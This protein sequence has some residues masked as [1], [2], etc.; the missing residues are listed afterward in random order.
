MYEWDC[1]YC[2]F[3]AGTPSQE[4]EHKKTC[5]FATNRWNILSR[6][7]RQTLSTGMIHVVGDDGKPMC[8][9]DAQLIPIRSLHDLI[10]MV[11]GGFILGRNVV[12]GGVCQKCLKTVN[13]IQPA[14]PARNIAQ[15]LDDI[16]TSIKTG[17]V[18]EFSKNIGWLDGYIR[19]R[20]PQ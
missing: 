13:N 2:G 5:N 1:P 18:K 3:H 17:D 9:R 15:L 20:V 12:K 6:Y 7:V 10:L 16:S 14:H 8:G 19:D 4:R 11:T